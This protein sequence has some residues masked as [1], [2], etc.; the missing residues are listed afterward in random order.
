MRART[1]SPD[2]RHD[3]NP[4][5]E[6]VRKDPKIALILPEHKMP[7]T[8]KEKEL[9]ESKLGPGK[10]SAKFKLVEQRLDIG[11]VGLKEPVGKIKLDEIDERIELNPNYDIDKPNKLTIKMMPDTEVTPP[12]PTDKILNPEKW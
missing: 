7:D 1:P 10:Y 4:K 2:Q 5:D 11:A 8:V 9:E 6:V 12:N 3:I